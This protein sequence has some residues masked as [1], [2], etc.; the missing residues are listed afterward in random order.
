MTNEAA[1]HKHGES[2]I[3][4][5]SDGRQAMLTIQQLSIV[6]ECN[7]L[8]RRDVFPAQEGRLEAFDNTA[9]D[10]AVILVLREPRCSN[11]WRYVNEFSLHAKHFLGFEIWRL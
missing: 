11:G 1:R 4:Q 3:A 2:A 9:P 6:G 8:M 5:L 10:G 7:A